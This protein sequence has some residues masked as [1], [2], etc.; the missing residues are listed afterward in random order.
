MHQGWICAAAAIAMLWTAGTG[1]A[2]ARP[3]SR[4]ADAP[5][6][7][8]RLDGMTGAPPPGRVAPKAP[9]ALTAPAARTAQPSAAGSVRDGYYYPPPVT[10]TTVIEYRQR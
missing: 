6:L 5:P 1:E 2:A 10:V 9:A 3:P 4:A 8:Y 7:P